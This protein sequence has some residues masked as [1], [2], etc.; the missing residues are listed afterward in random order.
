MM[1]RLGEQ[2]LIRS[3]ARTQQDNLPGALAD[4]NAIRLRAGL[5]NTEA[6]TKEEILASLL[7]ER[8]VEL[9]TESGHRWLDL[10][11]TGTIDNI[12][13]LITTEKGGIWQTTDQLYPIPA[14]DIQRNKNLI[15]NSGY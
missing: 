11:R 4:L 9:F 5:A 8:Q 7:H 1:L 2:Y 12:M 6:T 3:E 14:D 15:Q 13:P 10:K